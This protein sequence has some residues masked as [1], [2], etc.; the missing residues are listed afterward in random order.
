MVGLLGS[1]RDLRMEDILGLREEPI[2]RPKPVAR[3][4]LL[5]LQ[6]ER[7]LYRE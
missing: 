5:H 2:L 4:G 7:L 1:E 3:N 6:A